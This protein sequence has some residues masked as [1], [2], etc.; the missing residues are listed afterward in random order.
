MQ[1]GVES[2]ELDD[3]EEGAAGVQPA[4]TSAAVRTRDETGIVVEVTAAPRPLAA[5]ESVELDEQ[6]AMIAAAA[7]TTPDMRTMR[8]TSAP[9]RR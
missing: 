1:S 4:G 5:E 8:F 6:P 3:D 7:K 9:F 2:D